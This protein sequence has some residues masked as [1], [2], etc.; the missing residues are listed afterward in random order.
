MSASPA[1]PRAR[2]KNDDVIALFDALPRGALVYIA[3][4]GAPR[5]AP[6]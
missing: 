3:P 5:D 4:R 1:M 2:M 6:R